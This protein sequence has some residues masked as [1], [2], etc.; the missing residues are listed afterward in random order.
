MKRAILL[1]CLS[2]AGASGCSDP[3]PLGPDLVA[4]NC[5]CATT[6]ATGAANQTSGCSSGG[7]CEAP[8][9]NGMVCDTRGGCNAQCMNPPIPS[10]ITQT[11]TVT[12]YTCVNASNAAAA[13]EA[14]CG[15]FA[16][17]SIITCASSVLQAL[18][19]GD[20][21]TT[22]QDEV[23]SSFQATL[24]E[25]LQPNDAESVASILIEEC[26]T[27]FADKITG[28]CGVD[29]TSA[30]ATLGDLLLCIWSPLSIAS[31]DG[32]S[33]SGFTSIRTCAATNGSNGQTF[34]IQQ[35]NGCPANGADG[36]VDGGGGSTGT[37][38][39]GDPMP[40]TS[41]IASESSMVS[42]SGSDVSAMGVQPTGTAST[43]RLGPILMLSRLSVSLPDSTVNVQGN[44]VNLTGAFL[45]LSGPLA[46]AIDD[47]ALFTIPAGRFRGMV[48]GSV[49]GQETSVG[50][51]N[52]SPLTG[53]YDEE[54]G[55]FQLSG[56]VA[57]Q[58]V[59]A[60]VQI[61]L[62]F[63]FSN[64]PPFARAGSDQVVECTLPTREGVVQLS[65]AGSI[66]PD[67][68]DAIANYA[69]SVG[70]QSVAQG[71]SAAQATAL[72]GLGTR[73]VS[74]S[75]TDTHGSIS[76]DTAL[77]TVVDTKPPVFG[78]L[79]ALTV[80]VCAPTLQTIS[81]A[82][83][84]ATDACT[85]TA[86]SVSGQI[87]SS[88]GKTLATPIPL[89]NGVVTLP[90]GSHV[91]RWTAKDQAG[92]TSTATQALNV[93]TGLESSNSVTLDDRAQVR[94]SGG[95]FATIA[96]SGHG[97]TTG[98]QAQSGTIVSVG[99][100]FLRDRAIVNG[101]VVT[102]GKLTSQNLYTVT[103]TITENA[104]V[105]IPA[106][107]SLAGV[108]FP[109]SNAG[110][111][112]IPPNTPRTLAPGAYAAVT[113]FSGATLS[114]SSG[115]YFFDSLDLEPQSHL[116]LNQA[117]GP[118]KLFVKGTMIDRG[119]IATTAGSADGFVLGL[120]GSSGFFVESPFPAG[121]LIAPNSLV[122][123]TSLGVNA[124]RGQLFAKDIEIQPDAVFT[125]TNVPD[126]SP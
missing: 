84:K 53:Q 29:S 81:V 30:G 45:L 123:I 93:R 25:K 109:T 95:Q 72:V 125:C 62:V 2:V 119:Q 69:W 102:A 47:N 27:W 121:T 58:N 38:T 97:L 24:K 92:N 4:C 65:A 96:N 16:S 35:I 71:P 17:G 116:N 54:G 103:G 63:N 51:V 100:V 83:P 99:G 82:I 107:R 34:R 124:F 19:L 1:V 105:S 44:D 74:L 8:C 41:M 87:V 36:G 43:G 85:P 49:S 59:N 67:A 10:V 22:I 23:P 48:T 108:T 55:F 106:G 46:A 120:A 14:R 70:R 113:A 56:S 89:N 18:G 80:S 101:D 77:V 73:V 98:V 64:R 7:A 117:A 75:T 9:P 11:D 39:G 15:G 76:R 94:V 91:I 111:V 57:L 78:T 6:I 110:P 115:T 88:N 28:T 42:I 90:V 40:A 60:T 33:G 12:L 26:G 61:H 5:Q 86:V 122:T 3:I 13:C 21:V 52:S 50:A 68:G 126:S 66:D 20:L 31:V 112:S 104:T 37:T 118:V 32:D 79:P 114:L